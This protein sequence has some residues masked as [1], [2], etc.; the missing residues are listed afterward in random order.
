VV[1]YGRLKTKENFK[2]IALKVVV[3]ANERWSLTRGSKYSDLIWK[4]HYF[5][6]MVAE[7]RWSKP[8]VRL[9]Y[10]FEDREN[11][12][13]AAENLTFKNTVLYKMLTLMRFTVLF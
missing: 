5:G 1:A 6:E 13:Q 7:E 3:V 12:R 8:E 9:Y 10:H 2:L 4:L 11:R